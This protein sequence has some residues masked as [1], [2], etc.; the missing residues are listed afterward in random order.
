L[1]NK[2]IKIRSRPLSKAKNQNNIAEHSFYDDTVP[3]L[4]LVMEFLAVAMEMGAGLSTHEAAM[5]SRSLDGRSLDGEYES[6][7]RELREVFRID[8][9][10]LRRVS[11]QSNKYKDVSTYI[12]C[13]IV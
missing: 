8:P 13:S 9:L 1:H 11:N 6:L 3:V 4:Q 12:R 10:H 7:R 2:F 5:M